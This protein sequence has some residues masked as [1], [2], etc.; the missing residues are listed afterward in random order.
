MEPR[1]LQLSNDKRTDKGVGTSSDIEY[2]K[3]DAASDFGL[4]KE[5]S[6]ATNDASLEGGSL[7][8]TIYYFSALP[9]A[10]HLL[11]PTT[12]TQQLYA[13]PHDLLPRAAYPSPHLPASLFRHA[14]HPP[15]NGR[16][17]T[18]R[19]HVAENIALRDLRRAEAIARTPQAHARAAEI[20]AF[21]AG[22]YEHGSVYVAGLH[23]FIFSGVAGLGDRAEHYRE[24]LMRENPAMAD[25]GHIDPLHW[26]EV[27][28]LQPA[29]GYQC[30]GTSINST[31]S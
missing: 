7:Q 24:I 4:G 12:F 8:G 27:F 15:I 10:L 26:I 16:A 11:I 19:Y 2:N 6:G 29:H 28:I 21:A 5:G 20:R 17:I 30:R 3:N 22:A 23:L 25:E 14:A 31:L 18:E 1:R 9:I 13:I